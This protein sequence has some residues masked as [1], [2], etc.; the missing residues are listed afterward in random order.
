MNSQYRVS[1]EEAGEKTEM[2]KRPSIVNIVNFIRAVEPRD[3]QLDLYEPVREQLA[4]LEKYSIRGTFLLQYDALI[5]DTFVALLRDTPHEIGLWL[6]VVQPLVEDAGLRWRGRWPWDWQS[7]VGF[8]PGYT[9]SEREKFAD[10]LM[11]RFKA[12]FGYYPKSVAS[13]LIDAHSLA[14]LADKYHITASANCKEQ[15]GTDGYT[16]W[17][18]YYNQA[19]YPSRSNVL[20][21][22]QS[23]Q[24][25][26]PVPVFRMLGSDPIL[27]YDCGLD[28]SSGA[29]GAQGVITLEPVYTGQ[30]GGGGVPSWVDWFFDEVMTGCCL[31]FNYAQVGQENSFG[32]PAMRDGLTYQ[33][34]HLARLAKAGNIR[35]ETLAE[36]GAWFSKQY[37]VTPN[38]ATTALSDHKKEGK[39]AIW[40]CSKRYRVNYYGEGDA[41]WLRD[42]VLYDDAY[43]ER[44]LHDTCTSPEMIY[45]NLPVI[46]G[47]RWSGKGTRAGWYLGDAQG[48]LAVQEVIAEEAG[49]DLRLILQTGRGHVVITSGVDSI[50]VSSKI[51]DLRFGM[52]WGNSA[53]M[54]TAEIT[55]RELRLRHAGFAYTVTLLEG[56]FQRNEVVSEQGRVVLDLRG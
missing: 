44:Y 1:Y 10:I 52:V 39:K 37:P 49:E 12:V 56:S 14:Y 4:L 23:A 40:F 19:Y 16:L 18:G 46:D 28:L 29:A 38:S 17:G 25:Q 9:P 50:Q 15:W 45:D 31:S 36:S 54:D 24:T 21:P 6:E 26:I 34:E 33:I 27:Q 3:P 41:F 47:N 5:D 32:W 13:W 30:S 42:L 51:A 2:N 48:A 55:D 22:G 7:H 11:A 20:A 43:A 53:E 35:I 8:T